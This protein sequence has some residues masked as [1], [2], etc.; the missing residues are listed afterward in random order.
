[1]LVIILIVMIVL[2]ISTSGAA[3]RLEARVLTDIER[4]SYEET[5][6]TVRIVRDLRA[7]GV[8]TDEGGRM[9]VNVG[10]R[11]AHMARRKARRIRYALIVTSIAGLLAI[12]IK[13]L[14]GRQGQ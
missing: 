10:A 13:V 4:G 8:V 2:L 3:A 1:M 5:P 14:L 9:I 12:A 6:G 11:A 7:A